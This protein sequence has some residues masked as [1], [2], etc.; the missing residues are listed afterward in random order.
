MLGEDGLGP[1]RASGGFSVEGCG[2]GGQW[3]PFGGS[4]H[5]EPPHGHCGHE[6]GCSGEGKQEFCWWMWSVHSQ[7]S[8]ICSPINRVVADTTHVAA[9]S[10]CSQYCSASSPLKAENLSCYTRTESLLGVSQISPFCPSY[11]PSIF[12]F[13]SSFAASSDVT[14]SRFFEMLCLS[15]SPYSHTWGISS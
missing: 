3:S 9:Q 12:P 5:C 10:R 8:L 6:R 14:Q 11:S 13:K 4:G 1:G 7:T 2:L 15:L